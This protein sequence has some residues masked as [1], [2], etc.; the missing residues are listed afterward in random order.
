MRFHRNIFSN[1]ASP[2][3]TVYTG[4]TQ[5]CI[6]SQL[7]QGGHHCKADTSLRRTWSAWLIRPNFTCF[8]VT[9]LSLKADTSIRRTAGA[10]P[11]GVRLRESSLYT[12]KI[13]KSDLEN[14]L[15]LDFI[16]LFT[17]LQKLSVRMPIS[18]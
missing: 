13:E 3:P 16:M 1:L 2:M 17:V 7:S 14:F 5:V 15:F 10:S 8:S 6:Y 9:K 4:S 11:E 18:L 12:V